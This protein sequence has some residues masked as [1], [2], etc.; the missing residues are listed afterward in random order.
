MDLTPP[1][2]IGREVVYKLKVLLGHQKILY[3]KGVQTF[4]GGRGQRK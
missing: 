4:E 2:V 1:K 3:P